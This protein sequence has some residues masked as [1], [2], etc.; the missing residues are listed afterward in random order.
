MNALNIAV[1]GCGDVAEQVYLPGLDTSRAQGKLEVVALVDTRPD[2]AET[3]AGR[4]GI[5]HFY[6]SLD[7]VFAADDVDLIVN[8]TNMQAH[9]AVIRAAVLAGKHVYSE[10][11][12]VLTLEESADILELAESAGVVVG[13]APAMLLHPEIEEA[14]RLIRRG[15]IGKVSFARGRGSHPGP[16]RLRDFVTDPSWF[17]AAGAGPLFDLGVYPLTAMTAALGSVRRVTAFSGKAIPN[18]VAMY[19]PA[20]GNPITVEADDNTHVLLDFGD[21]CFAYVDATYCVLSSKGPRMEFYGETGVMNLAADP[22]DPPIEL[23]TW[24]R[25]SEL[26]GWTTPEPVYRGRVWPPGRGAF[27]ANSF[28]FVRGIEHMA[29][30]ISGR[31]R[32]LLVDPHHATHVLEVMLAAQTSALTGRAIDVSTS[33]SLPFVNEEAAPVASRSEP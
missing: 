30:Y 4:H 8:L 3:L 1:V 31:D 18:R 2:R 22:T 12:F 16:D 14:I 24:D 9:A 25:Q 29:D 10:K 23:F 13:S 11:P 5:P 26:R 28:N 19:G 33:F 15:A 7:E 17:Y 6:S 32:E 20:A 21:A 27:T